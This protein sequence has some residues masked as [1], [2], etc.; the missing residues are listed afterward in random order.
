MHATHS[1]SDLDTSAGLA[2]ENGCGYAIKNNRVTIN[3]SKLA[4]H[5]S[6]DNVSGTLSVEF[7]ALK[8]P[9]N[10]GDFKGVAVAGTTVGEMFGQ[11][12]LQNCLY[13]LLFQEPP[14]GTWYLTLMLREW[15]ECGYVTR[16]F[17]N[18]ST[19]YVVN[20]K[21]AAVRKDADNVISV[22]FNGNKST[23]ATTI[24]ENSEDTAPATESAGA[25]Q[26]DQKTDSSVVSLNHAS[27]HEIASVKGV[28][29]KLAENIVSERPFESFMDVLKVKGMG[30]KLLEK[31]RQFIHL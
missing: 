20:A 13:D 14:A 7:W 17:V 3:V 10:G 2:L 23:T 24:Q 29:K 15:T 4:S 27:A 26:S 28:S 12:Y 11:H 18:F 6:A 25:E 1:S 19:A 21:P 31:I 5:R 8:Q 30:P 16:D 9:Y 22:S